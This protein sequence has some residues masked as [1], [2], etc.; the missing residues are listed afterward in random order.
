MNNDIT[1]Q[2]KCQADVQT[3]ISKQTSFHSKLERRRVQIR[4]TIRLQNTYF[5]PG[6]NPLRKPSSSMRLTIVWPTLTD[7]DLMK[8]W[9]G[10]P[11]MEI[12]IT[13]DWKIGNP[14]IITGFHPIKFENIYV[15]S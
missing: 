2:S 9:M 1:L 11:T 12:E 8:Q 15:D 13:T 3:E 14:I 4:H 6:Y 5:E 7:P 10:E